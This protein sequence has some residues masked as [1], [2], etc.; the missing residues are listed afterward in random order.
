MNVV[1]IGNHAAGLSAAETLRRND[2]ECKITI[3]SKEQTPPYSRCL[4]PYIVSGEKQTDEILFR[5]EDFYQSNSIETMFGK[6]VVRVLAD[7]KAVLLADGD[8][9]S[10]DSLIIAAGGSPATLKVP[11]S[12]NDGVFVFRNL[13]DADRIMQYSENAKRAVVLGGGLVG[14]KAAV[15]LNKRG[16]DVTVMVGSPNVLSQIV[17]AHEAE[18]FEEHLNALGIEVATRNNPSLIMGD[19]KV[20]GVETTEGRKFPCEMV[21]VGKG[22]RANIGIVEGTNIETEYGIV[23]DEH[24]RTSVDGVYAAG[25]VTQS[26]D[27]VRGQSWTNALWPHAVEEGR[28]AAENLLGI[29]SPLRPRTSMN[30]FTIG[31]LALISAGLTGAREEVEGAEEMAF[32]GPQKDHGRRFLFKNGKI[33]GY[34]LVGDVRNAG[35]LT[36]LVSR[37]ADV[38]KVK[39]SIMQGKFDFPSMLPVIR[40]NSEK[41]AEPEYQEVIG[42]L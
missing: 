15:A 36:S 20:E 21:I 9:V 42:L 30:A 7:E 41:F 28:V 17:S 10:Y 24:C 3:I 31:E 25:D 8:K 23:V 6:E 18:I 4:I 13:D 39:D 34:A 1:I 29:D 35:V 19:G 33:V 40:D 16:L 38:T 37:G 14:L 27:N 2:K 26:P 22:V 5:P 12:Q 11:G 32:K